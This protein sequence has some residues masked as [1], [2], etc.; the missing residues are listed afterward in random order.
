MGVLVRFGHGCVVGWTAAAQPEC[1]ADTDDCGDD[2]Q[3]WELVHQAGCR[4][5]QCAV[6][7]HDQDG[8]GD[9]SGSAEQWGDEGIAK[10]T[11]YLGADGTLRPEPGPPD[12][13]AA[14]FTYDPADPTPTVGGPTL[15]PKSAGRKDNAVL[16]SRADVLVH[17]GEALTQPVEV[18]GPVSARFTLRTSTDHADV[19][20]RLCDV[21]PED[22][23]IN[24]C[25]GLQTI[26]PDSHPADQDGVRTVDVGMWPTAWRFKPGHRLRVQVSGGSFPQYARNTGTGEPLATATHLTR[27]D[28][29]ILPS[30]AITLS[31]R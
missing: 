8:C 24:V 30:S 4:A 3:P 1:E 13:P 7:V 6:V 27:I 25:D 29:E 28:Y 21:D 9:Q 17:T 16:E 31:V 22:R 23:S 26:A 11:L 15:E 5:G 18:I 14:R 20:V 12:G 10:Q 19:F 2:Q